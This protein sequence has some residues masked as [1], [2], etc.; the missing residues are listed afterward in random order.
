[1]PSHNNNNTE[2]NNMTAG[3][4]QATNAQNNNSAALPH[5]RTRYEFMR[6]MNAGSLPLNLGLSIGE[7]LGSVFQRLSLLSLQC[8][9]IIN[10]LTH[11]IL[12]SAHAQVTLTSALA[13]HYMNGNGPLGIN[14]AHPDLG[15]RHSSTDSNNSNSSVG[16]TPS[17]SNK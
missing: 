6:A 16:T 4:D 14:P 17:K 5:Y 13:Q 8:Q 15:S 7:R 10:G 9:N 1:M 11:S 3:S 12:G 2:M